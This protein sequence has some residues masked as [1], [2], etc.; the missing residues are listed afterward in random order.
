MD[1]ATR[2]TFL[3][4]TLIAPA[5]SAAEPGFTP[6]FNGRDM[7]GWHISEVNHHGNTKAWSVKDGVLMVTQDPP[8]N[9]GI[10]LTDRKY[11][12]FEITLEINPDWGC[13][14]GLFLRSTEKG[15]A[16]QVLLDYLEGG[17]IG[18]IYGER[19][20]EVNKD[21]GRGEKINAEWRKHW[22]EGTWNHLRARIE[23]D[24][25]HIQTWLNGVKLVDWTD[26]M[27]HA[28]DGAAE[29]MIA[30][31]AHRSDPKAKTSRWAA[32]GYHRYRNIVVKVL[33]P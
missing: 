21:P 19:L 16:Y 23:G 27:N 2:R 9:G 33:R 24:V 10:L 22:K 5:V 11:R 7:T 29:G 14:G 25:P 6:I 20:P 15:E 4:S 32:G 26:S 13:D 30:L 31:Q 28:V 1:R 18:G 3:F 8:G 12:D 17:I